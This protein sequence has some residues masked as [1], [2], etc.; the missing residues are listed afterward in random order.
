VSTTRTIGGLDPATHRLR[1]LKLPVI[2]N[3][4]IISYM[5]DGLT[6]AATQ[7]RLVAVLSPKGA[8]KSMA[9]DQALRAAED[10]EDAKVEAAAEYLPL[11]FPRILSPRSRSRVEILGAMWKPI[12]G[13]EIP[14][15]VRGKARPYEDLI[16]ELMVH[17]VSMNVG[18]LVFDEAE[19][20]S[21]EGLTVIGDVMKAAEAK[22]HGRYGEDGRRF[23]ASGVG[24]LLVG[25]T[26]LG[27]KLQTWEEAEQRLLQVRRVGALEPAE[28]SDIYR[29]YLPAF[30]QRA[31]EDEESWLELIRLQVCAGRPIT[32][33][34]IE[35]HT[36]TYVTRMY[37]QDA[38]LERPE[39]VPWSEEVFFE[40]LTELQV[41]PVRAS[42]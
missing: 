27:P 3:L 10:A 8:G 21:H 29:R 4:P 41:S 28:A 31:E 16:E 14:R 11:A 26:R 18:V 38:E 42:A 34:E 22:G 12:T 5:H 2:E 6:L 19:R 36:R 15:I 13:A 37:A 9:L 1:N 40:T 39:D 25:T 7:R 23:A 20:L 33:R 32:L 17:L 35:N 24:V 30:E